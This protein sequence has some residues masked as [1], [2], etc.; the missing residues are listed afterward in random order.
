MANAII[1]HG[2]KFKDE[3][4]KMQ[5]PFC[6]SYWYPWLQ[7]K[8]IVAGVPT[9]V[10]SFTNSW[11]P[12][13]NYAADV[14]ILQRQIINEK[15]ILIGHSCG[16]GLLVKY[17]SENPEI[18]IG[19]LVLVAPWIDVL[20]Q[21]PEYFNGFSPDPKLP[22]RIK[23]IDLFY[24]TDDHYGDLILKGCDKLQDLYPNMRVHKFS[25]K[26]HFSGDMHQFPEMWNLCETFIN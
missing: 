1:C 9:Q 19:H 6:A 12:A 17:L 11:L 21:F 14:D 26:S 4:Y 3:F 20:Y 18:K 10:P 25:D 23:T 13:R 8:L 15:T 22:D 2:V 5:I 16:G 7:Q 24:S